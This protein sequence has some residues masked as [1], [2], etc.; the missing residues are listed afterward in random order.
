MLASASNWPAAVE[1]NVADRVLPP[2]LDWPCMVL[3][4]VLGLGSTVA[5]V[6]S[7]AGWARAPGRPAATADD[8]ASTIAQD[9]ATAA[10]A[11]TTGAVWAIVV[12][13]VVAVIGVVGL[14]IAL[15]GGVREARRYYRFGS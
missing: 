5:G 7:V 9:E 4:G 10:G 6:L 13:L 14:V 2:H 11:V 3:A 12:S 8:D 1:R 15:A